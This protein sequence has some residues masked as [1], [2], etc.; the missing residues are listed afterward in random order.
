MSTQQRPSFFPPKLS[1]WSGNNLSQDGVTFNF[2][3]KAFSWLPDKCNSRPCGHYLH[4]LPWRLWSVHSL[5]FLR[6]WSGPLFHHAGWEPSLAESS[7]LLLSSTAHLTWKVRASRNRIIPEGRGIFPP[8]EDL[9][10]EA[11]V[12]PQTGLVSSKWGVSQPMHQMLSPNPLGNKFTQDSV[13]SGVSF[14]TP[15]GL[16]PQARDPRVPSWL[17]WKLCTP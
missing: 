6:S 1:Q 4:Y 3:Q 11:S 10:P 15:A 13:D 5:L 8:L 14:I 12:W 2:L 9:S 7:I 16:G 17:L